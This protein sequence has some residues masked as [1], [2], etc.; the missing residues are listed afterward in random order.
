[1]FGAFRVLQTAESRSRMVHAFMRKDIRFVPTPPAVVEAMLDL[2][3]F[4]PDDCLYD[5]GCGDGL[6]VLAAARRGG[7][8]VGLDI[9]GSLLTRARASA[10]EQGLTS[11]TEFRKENIFEASIAE[12]T[13]VSLYLGFSVNLA[14]RPK[15]LTELAP[16]TRIVSHS[17]HMEGW[18]ADSRIMVEAK[19]IYLWTV[20]EPSDLLLTYP[21]EISS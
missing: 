12:A 20:V 1:M 5:L 13:V 4:G 10:L 2:A 15:L 8:G 16:G 7:R 3:A 6:L 21:P 17:Y 14:L 9:D 19:W 18:R 11:R